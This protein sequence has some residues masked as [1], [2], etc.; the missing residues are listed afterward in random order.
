MF[1]ITSGKGFHIKF[2]NGYEVSVQ[3]GLGNYCEARLRHK[4]TEHTPGFERAGEW[5]SKTAEV[6][7]FDPAGNVC[8]AR[9]ITGQGDNAGF[10]TPEQVAEIIAAVSKVQNEA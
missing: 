2:A 8:T 3:W 1:T 4:G 9:F 5:N 10:L 7:V 6:C